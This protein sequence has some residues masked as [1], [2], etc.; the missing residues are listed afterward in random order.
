LCLNSQPR[1]AEAKDGK[2]IFATDFSPA[3]EQ[4]YRHFLKTMAPIC[5]EVVIY[6]D[7]SLIHELA[8]YSARWDLNAVAEPTLYEAQEGWVKE[9]SE[10]WLAQGER[11]GMKAVYAQQRGGSGVAQ[12]IAEAALSF[13]VSLVVMASHEGPFSAA[14]FG[15]HARQVLRAGE[16]PVL[17]YGPAQ[18][19]L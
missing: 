3:C 5:Q 12:S 8:A 6:H 15:S 18:K 19:S 13:D 10:K 2:A 4:A 17:I 1:S 11:S 16:F 9:Q 14:L 7:T